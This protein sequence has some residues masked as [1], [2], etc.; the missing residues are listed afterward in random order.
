[1]AID[2]MVE[3]HLHKYFEEVVLLEQKFIINDAMSVKMGLDNLL[4]DVGLP[5]KIG[6]FFRMEVGE[7]IQR[8]VSRVWPSV[9]YY[10]IHMNLV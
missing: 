3:G 4:K 5:M 9:C 1:M 8:T 7:G 2:K 6:S 10:F